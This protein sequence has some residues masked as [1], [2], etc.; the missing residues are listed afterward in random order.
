[1]DIWVRCPIRGNSREH[2]KH[3]PFGYSPPF[4]RGKDVEGQHGIIKI[5]GRE[6][7]DF[8]TPPRTDKKSLRSVHFD[9][10]ISVGERS[11]CKP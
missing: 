1:M 9:L 3:T 7:E 4:L 10:Y 2:G 8:R 11:F 6:L 5:Q